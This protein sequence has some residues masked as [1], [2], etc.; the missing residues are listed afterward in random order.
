MAWG[1][2]GYQK[3]GEE[4][5]NNGHMDIFQYLYQRYQMFP[6]LPTTWSLKVIFKLTKPVSITFI[7]VKRLRNLQDHADQENIDRCTGKSH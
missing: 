3:V 4:F 6:R 7:L 2:E 5:F 1:W